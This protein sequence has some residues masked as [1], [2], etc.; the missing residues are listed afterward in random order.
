MTDLKIPEVGESVTGGY[1][2]AWLKSEGDFV[3]AGEEVLEL[4]TDKATLAV[5][6]PVSGVLKITVKEGEEVE[7]GQTVG[8]LDTEARPPAAAPPADDSSVSAEQNPAEDH[9]SPSVRH[10][11]QTYGL[12]SIEGQGSG[13]KGHVT[14]EDVLNYVKEKG[15]KPLTAA[16]AAASAEPVNQAPVLTASQSLPAQ[17]VTREKMSRIRQKIAANLVESRRESAHLTTFNE[18]D[19]SEVMEMRKLYQEDF[20]NARGVKLGFMSFFVKAVCGA[21]REYPL[22]NAVIEGDEIVYRRSLN[23]G[24]AVSTEKG[25]ITPV[26]RKA[27]TLSFSAIESQIIS[28]AR[29]A[30]DRTLL[31]DELSGGTFTIT[32]GG[33]FGSLLSTPIPSPGQSGI[34]GMHSIVRKPVALGDQIVIR[35]MMFL[36]LTYDHRI[37]DGREAVGFL[38]RVKKDIEDPRRILIDL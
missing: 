29:R 19:M 27:D 35:P 18:V 20:Q 13:R 14:K 1:L 12:T 34:L 5:P 9:Y 6:S 28:F 37:V 23:V 11:L 33:I 30:A 2:A 10:T 31:P 16:P 24:I 21:L 8:Q 38:T 15:L 17:E 7:I 4:E 36:A 25:L 26:L 32:N 3:S 22:I